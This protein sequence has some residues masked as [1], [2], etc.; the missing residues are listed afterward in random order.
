M[1]WY[2]RHITDYQT[3]TRHLTPTE[4]GIYTL[5]LDEYYLSEK[6]LPLEMDTLYRLTNSRL[7]TEMSAVEKIIETF[8]EKK[9]KGFI[10]KR[11]K[12]EITLYHEKCK[13]NQAVGRLGGRPN[14]PNGNPNG[15]PDGYVLETQKKPYKKRIDKNIKERIYKKEKPTFMTR[16]QIIDENTR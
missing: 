7:E 8:F 5:L 12:N 15:N 1:N 13:R 3:S 2:K 11:A 9:A 6:P 14:N 4:H 16:E 10:Q